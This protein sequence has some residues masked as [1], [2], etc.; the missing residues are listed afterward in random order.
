M[1]LYSGVER[2][3]IWYIREEKHFNLQSDLLDLLL[4]YVF[5]YFSC[6]HV[7]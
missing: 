2:G 6:F 4:L 1:G 7:V 3:Y 5:R